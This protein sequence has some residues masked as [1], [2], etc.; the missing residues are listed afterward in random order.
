MMPPTVMVTAAGFE[1]TR[2][3]KARLELLGALALFES[4]AMK[5][6][7]V[8]QSYPHDGLSRPGGTERMAEA[9][10]RGKACNTDLLLDVDFFSL[11]SEP[12]EALRERFGIPPKSARVRELDPHGALQ[13]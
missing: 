5:A 1:E 2:A 4:G 8:T 13:A 6:G 10:T 7:V 11:A 12:L 3:S 9:I